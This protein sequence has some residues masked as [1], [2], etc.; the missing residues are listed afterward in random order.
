MSWF[1]VSN[2]MSNTDP[3][4]FKMAFTFTADKVVIEVGS[5]IGH[6]ACETV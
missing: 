6:G 2:G 1:V 3:K 4:T 5:L